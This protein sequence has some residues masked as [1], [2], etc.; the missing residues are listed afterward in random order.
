MRYGVVAS[1]TVLYRMPIV[2]LDFETTGLAAQRGDRVCEVGL[3]AAEGDRA[4]VVL[5]S[6][7]DPKRPLSQRTLEITGIDEQEL[8]DAPD[9]ASLLPQIM[10]CIGGAPIVMHNAP[11]DLFFLLEQMRESGFDPPSN[12]AIDTLLMARFLD[13]NR[14]GNSLRQTAERYGIRRARAHRAADDALATALAFH[15][16][17]PYLELRGVRTAGDLVN[18][19][20]A[21]SA[22]RF[23]ERPSSMLL[24]MVSRAV[25]LELTVE[26]LYA[27]APGASSQSRRVRA[28]ALEEE[29]YLIGWDLD[30]EAERTFRLD[31]ILA[32]ASEDSSYMSPWI[33]IDE[34]PERFRK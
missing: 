5:S 6:F 23:A 33:T 25:A 18:G 20:M 21:G 32:L 16:L 11:F 30:H 26:I 7:V 9:L 17:V 10:K 28:K 12:L 29:R 14:E 34:L 3:V 1:D 4:E 22:E 31:R 13:R 24:D 15:A 8:V 19:R 27:R 2:A